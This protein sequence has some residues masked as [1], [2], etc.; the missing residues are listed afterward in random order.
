MEGA[1]QENRVEKSEERERGEQAHAGRGRCAGRAWVGTRLGHL[2]MK[3]FVV[4]EK[5]GGHAVL[6]MHPI[7]NH[8]PQLTDSDP[9][10]FNLNSKSPAVPGLADVEAGDI[11]N[12]G[13]SVISPMIGTAEC[14][15]RGVLLR[16][17]FV[18][19]VDGACCPD[20]ELEGPA[21]V[22][23]LALPLLP[24]FFVFGLPLLAAAAA[25]PNPAIPEPGLRT[26]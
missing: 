15:K 22:G 6:A 21:A 25:P 5:L 11:D 3:W 19:D 12:V 16:F 14:G 20:Q 13:W 23:L 10:F 8:W 2:M 17:S 24:L 7:P 26:R 9:T 18:N 4:G 1:S